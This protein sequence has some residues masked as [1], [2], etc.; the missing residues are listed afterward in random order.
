MH[1]SANASHTMDAAL[2]LEQVQYTKTTPLHL[3]KCTC[4]QPHYHT[5]PIYR[6]GLRNK[7]PNARLLTQGILLDLYTSSYAVT[8]TRQVQCQL[9]NAQA[10]GAAAFA[11]A[12]SRLATAC[13]C[14][15]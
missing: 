10:A 9:G 1:E 6:T 15:R 5:R 3:H 8:K 4:K 14:K 7:H 11:A 2:S 12:G 13:C